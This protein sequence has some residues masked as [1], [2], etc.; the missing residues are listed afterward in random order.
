MSR[1]N[2]RALMHDSLSARTVSKSG[3]SKK[4][5]PN[6]LKERVSSRKSGKSA[7]SLPTVDRVRQSMRKLP[8]SPLFVNLLGGTESQ[9]TA[10]GQ[11]HCVGS[12]VYFQCNAVKIFP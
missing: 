10:L 7:S 5:G 9:S 4:R 6:K 3:V 2:Q 11:R 12:I 8:C 1:T